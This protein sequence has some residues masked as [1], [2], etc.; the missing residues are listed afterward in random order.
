MD[1]NKMKVELS[2]E[3]QHARGYSFAT[4]AL[5]TGKALLRD[6]EQRARWGVYSDAM[7]II[8]VLSCPWAPELCD[9]R[10]DVPTLDELNYLAKRLSDLSLEE[11]TVYRAL[12]QRRFGDGTGIEPVSVEELINMTFDLDQVP[13]AS[14]IQTDAELGTFVMEN[15]LHPDVAAIPEE[16]LYLLDR[17]RI[18]ALQREQM[19]GLFL[20]GLYIEAGNY[21]L[22]KVYQS[23]ER[24]VDEPEDRA[25]FRLQSARSSDRGWDQPEESL[26]WIELPVSQ[27]EAVMIAHRHHEL[28]VEECM[29]FAVESAIP[30]IGMETIRDLSDFR[31][32]NELAEQYLQMSETDQIKFKAVLQ[33]NGVYDLSD[34][35]YQMENLQQYEFIRTVPDEAVF[36]K[37]YLAHHLGQ[38]FDRR[39]LDTLPDGTEGYHLLERLGAKMT[40]YGIV[41]APGVSLFQA[42][43]FEPL[44]NQALTGQDAAEETGLALHGDAAAPELAELTMGG[45]QL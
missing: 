13:I 28:C 21:V 31:Q 35:L 5:P 15:D 14:N 24:P 30:Q 12:C 27:E 38:D 20:N 45:M 9:L 10:L 26:E 23:V 3:S 8:K 25:V 39:W 22:P 36:F 34:A 7:E 16:S 2:S 6:A 19:G 29:L 44:R 41:S 40:E 4:V 32:L 18:G 33:R 42:V 37:E 11:Q 43:S 17:A 1:E